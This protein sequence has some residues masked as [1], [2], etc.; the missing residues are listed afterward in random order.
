[1]V[2]STDKIEVLIIGGGG[3]VGQNIIR[4]LDSSKYKFIIFDIKKFPKQPDV[5]FIKG[6]VRDFNSVKKAVK[7]KNLILDLAS[8]R[9]VETVNNPIRDLEVTSLGALNILEACRLFNPTCKVVFF[10]SSLEFGDVGNLP[11]SEEN[12]IPIPD[13]FY[14]IHKGTLGDYSR[15]YWKLRHINSTV[16]RFS[17]IYGPEKGISD[18]MS[19]VNYFINLAMDGKKIQIY[20]NGE[21]K[22]DYVFVDDAINALDKAIKSNKSGGQTFN[23]G[24]GVPI[25]LID[26]V[27]LVVKIVGTG[28]IIKVPWPKDYKIEPRD[29]Y[30]DITKAS[31]VLS[32]K[33]TYN[34]QDGIKQT[35]IVMK[36]NAK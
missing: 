11:V 1:M 3:F 7:G 28:K 20:G 26:M 8:L 16:L 15:L 34:L 19:I 2:K 10:G 31:K 17:N 6:D 32:W 35:M 25:K 36:S 29:Y 9:P 5:K 14:G 23:I 33:P 13:S 22:R 21:Q 12:N 18:N 4:K 24:S 30:T 27:K